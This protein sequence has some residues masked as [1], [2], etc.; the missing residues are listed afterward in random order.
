VT[1]PRERCGLDP[2]SAYVLRALADNRIV[3]PDPAAPAGDLRFSLEV[4]PEWFRVLRLEPRRELV[5]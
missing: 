4:D 1:L 2:T 5:S 3:E